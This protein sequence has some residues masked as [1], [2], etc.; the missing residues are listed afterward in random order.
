MSSGIV[1]EID[2]ICG[3]S[4]VREDFLWWPQPKPQLLGEAEEITHSASLRVAE[5]NSKMFCNS[6]HPRDFFSDSSFP[7]LFF[8]VDSV[9]GASLRRSSDI[10]EAIL[11]GS[12]VNAF[13]EA[14]GAVA[15]RRMTRQLSTHAIRRR[16]PAGLRK[17]AG[18]C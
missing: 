13:C 8:P 5:K 16:S 18:L 2:N 11:R 15:M 1:L 3:F 12:T 9:L 7:P 17:A 6:K 10:R 14:D 4:E